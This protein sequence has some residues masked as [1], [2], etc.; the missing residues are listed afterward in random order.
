GHSGNCRLGFD[1]P[2]RLARSQCRRHHLVLH[3]TRSRFRAGSGELLCCR[4]CRIPGTD[5]E[6]FS[7]C[8]DHCSCSSL[9]GRPTGRKL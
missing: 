5:P 1:R 2:N 3:G 4:H 9:R 7:Q 8:W 6:F